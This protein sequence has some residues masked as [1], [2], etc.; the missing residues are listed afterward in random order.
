[1]TMITN[2][3]ECNFIVKE[4]HESDRTNKIKRE[5]LFTMKCKLSK[6]NPNLEFYRELK[7]NYL[8]YNE[9]NDR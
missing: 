2:Q 9:I 4:T 5:L 8:K 7:H 6:S 3:K 1:M